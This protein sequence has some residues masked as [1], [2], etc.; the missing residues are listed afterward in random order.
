MVNT[1]K[2]I[3]SVLHFKWQ[4]W[5]AE[6]DETYFAK[7]NL[8]RDGDLMPPELFEKLSC[9]KAG[10]TFSLRFKSNSLFRHSPENICTVTQNQF[11]PPA[12]FRGLKPKVGRFYPIGFFRCFSGIFSTNP[13]PVRVISIDKDTITIDTNNPIA[14]YDLDLYC[15]VTDV[16]EKPAIIGGECVWWCKRPFE[17]GPGMQVPLE[18]AETDFE[19]NSAETF[20]RT[21]ERD[22]REF[23]SEPRL[24]THIDSVCHG[25]LQALYSQILPSNSKIL[26]LMSS[27]QSH[28]PTQISCEVTGLGINDAEMKA[29]PIL[30]DFYVQ[31]LNRD[32]SIP[33]PDNTFDAVTCDLSIEY[34]VKP[35]D[36][37]HEIRRVLKKGGI[38]TFSFSDRY[39]PEKVINLWESLHDFER[40]GY[41]IEIMR[42]AGGFGNY[43]TYSYRGFKRPFDDKH[44]GKTFLSDPLYV[45]TAI[46]N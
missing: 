36:V 22:D 12:Q 45:V 31:N 33:F 26:D 1:R 29:N 27:Y 43:K 24:T 39:F 42:K 3:S 44:F 32:P 19:L 7:I 41:V 8:W 16:N 5:L 46:K 37:M 25:H 20:S 10:D 11:F 30:H 35:L 17:Y 40:M 23:Y 14:R 34:L 6:H 9:S 21:D 38:T 15:E 2:K 18:D 13:Q 28:I 4:S